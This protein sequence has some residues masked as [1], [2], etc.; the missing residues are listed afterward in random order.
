VK[1]TTHLQL[2]PRSRKCGSIHP[3][4]YTSSWRSAQLVKH[5]DNFFFSIDQSGWLQGCTTEESG[6]DP[7]QM[8][9]IV[10]FP[11]VSR[12]ALGSTKLPIQTGVLLQVV[13][14]PR[15]EADHS[16]LMPSSCT[17]GSIPPLH[18]TSSRLV[19]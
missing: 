10:L 4:P 9:E 15:P 16:Q 11:T 13:K 3:L 7:L 2:V 17:R 14:V 5:R 1:L 12:Q 18:Y 19:A 8:Q 6:F